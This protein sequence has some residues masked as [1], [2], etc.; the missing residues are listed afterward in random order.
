MPVRKL[1]QNRAAL[2]AADSIE[3]SPAASDKGHHEHH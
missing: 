1:D 2:E 3:L